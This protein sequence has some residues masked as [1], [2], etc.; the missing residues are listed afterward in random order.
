MNDKNVFYVTRFGF[1]GL[2]TTAVNAC[3][4]KA[5][6][7]YK[8]KSYSYCNRTDSTDVVLR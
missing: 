6:W 8:S 4:C 5:T 7:Q 1:I 3:I 2:Q